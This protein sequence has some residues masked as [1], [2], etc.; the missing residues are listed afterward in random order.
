MI[1]FIFMFLLKSE[2]RCIVVN[3]N[4]SRSMAVAAKYFNTYFVAI[5]VRVNEI[6]RCI[7]G[8][9][10]RHKLAT[11]RKMLNLKQ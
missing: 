11:S 2:R 1:K 4:V 3:I 9:R 6:L 7:F 8:G 5:S 10:S